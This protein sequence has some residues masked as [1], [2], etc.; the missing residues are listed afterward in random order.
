MVSI[1]LFES[2]GLRSVRSASAISKD[3]EGI[4]IS[5]LI[6]SH[7]KEELEELV[8]NSFTY[9][10]VLSKMGY[11]TGHGQNHKTLKERLEY[12]NIS[13]QHFRRKSR[14]KW[15]DETIFCENS[16]VS[17]HKLRETFKQKEIMPYQCEVCGLPPF[18]NNKPLVL[19]LDHKNGK[20]KDN[21]IE[22]LRWICPN[23]DRQSDTYGMRNKKKLNKGVVLYNV[24][25]DETKDK[26]VSLNITMKERSHYYC[27]DC[28]KEISKSS[29]RCLECAAI[30]RR[31]IQRPSKEELHNFLINHNGNFMAVGRVYN[32]TDNTVRKWCKE[33]ELP[34]HTSDYVEK[35]PPKISK[36]ELQ[37]PIPCYM[38]DKSTN[39]IIRE[40]PSRS[41]A[42][43]YLGLKQKKAETH[44]GS[45]CSGK[46]KT[47]YGYKWANKNITQQNDY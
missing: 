29:I 45:V 16:E 43:R 35:K 10:D 11:S 12:Y 37:M 21:R 36:S 42:A 2:F 9:V 27:I 8:A 3:K 26:T 19:T 47:A 4:N 7:T 44:I 13:T 25:T 32:V 17:Q 40:F 39:E 28:G 15:T 41:E 34:F 14:K 38:I 24:P 22:N 18:W 33:Y 6:D 20:N 1:K 5:S 23:C 30:S 31:I 46:R